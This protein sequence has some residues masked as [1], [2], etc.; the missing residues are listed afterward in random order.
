MTGLYKNKLILDG[1]EFNKDTLKKP[2]KIQIRGYN[3][4]AL[5]SPVDLPSNY[6]YTVLKDGIK[7]DG[8]IINNKF[9]VDTLGQ[10]LIIGIGK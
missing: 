5:F 4:T 1:F 6:N 8:C 2:S 3:V 7:I 9:S 10:Y